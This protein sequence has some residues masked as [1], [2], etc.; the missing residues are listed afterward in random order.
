MVRVT[1]IEDGGQ[2]KKRQ[3]EGKRSDMTQRWPFM[4]PNN[5]VIFD[6][7]GDMTSVDRIQS[8]RIP[9]LTAVQTLRESGVESSLR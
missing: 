2:E 4:R 7:P 3:Y 5:F 8:L 1:E 6:F 9:L